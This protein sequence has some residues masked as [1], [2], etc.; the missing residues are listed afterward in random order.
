VSIACNVSDDRGHS[1]SAE[2]SV[3]IVAPQP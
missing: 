1:A 2:T 3:T